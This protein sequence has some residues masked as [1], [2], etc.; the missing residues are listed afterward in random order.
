MNR[1][2]TT[3]SFDIDRENAEDRE[4]RAQQRPLDLRAVEALAN[5]LNGEGQS[6]ALALL[7]ALRAT[8][9][10]NREL[11]NHLGLALAAVRNTC[12]VTIGDTI[13]DR[14]INEAIEADGRAAAVLAQVRDEEASIL[15]PLRDVVRKNQEVAQ[16]RALLLEWLETPFFESRKDWEQWASNFRV[17]V[18]AILLVGKTDSG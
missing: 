3:D 5:E 4:R 2:G 17:R 9:A 16:L 13:E 11:R 1:D 15:D 7:A 8:R 18:R 6:F 10:S 12:G 14:I